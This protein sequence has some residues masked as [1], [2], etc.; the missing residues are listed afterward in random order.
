MAV[1]PDGLIL[2][3]LDGLEWQ[4]PS[5]PTTAMLRGVAYGEGLFRAVGEGGTILS[6]SNGMD[7]ALSGTGEPEFL[8]AAV[9]G[10]G[11]WVVVGTG[12]AIWS[13]RPAP[14]P[15]DY[16]LIDPI[17]RD[18]LGFE[19]QVVGLAAGQTATVQFTDTLSIFPVWT[20][21]QAITGSGP[22]S[23]VTVLDETADPEIPRFYRLIVP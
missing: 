18:G 14:L 7:W 11:D 15:S 4:E 1:G 10:A 12:G 2:T 21:G 19:F 17:W 23:P 8:F 6:S 3:S 13:T 5:S 22:S 20:D 16:A 9:S